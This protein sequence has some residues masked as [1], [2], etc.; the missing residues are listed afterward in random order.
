MTRE[1][2]LDEMAARTAEREDRRD[3][4]KNAA[5]DELLNNP[6]TPI[7]FWY[8]TY[9]GADGNLKILKH[10]ENQSERYLLNLKNK[11]E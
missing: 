5:I 1:E 9:I 11:R 8:N 10:Y 4:E 6:P 2:G 3:K 7:F